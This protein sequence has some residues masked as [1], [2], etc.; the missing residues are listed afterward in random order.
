[1]LITRKNCRG[2]RHLKTFPLVSDN[3]V[4]GYQIGYC[5]CGCNERLLLRTIDAQELLAH[6]FSRQKEYKK[7]IQKL[8]P[9]ISF[10][11]RLIKWLIG[12]L[13]EHPVMD[14]EAVYN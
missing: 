8:T 5:A 9:K 10:S 14:G 7:L 13:G 4:L 3:G 2:G 6:L 1:M 12:R 11:K